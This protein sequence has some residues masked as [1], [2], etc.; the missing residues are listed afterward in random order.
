MK[1]AVQKSSLNQS[2]I[3]FE[4][5]WGIVAILFF[6]LFSASIGQ[7]DYPQWYSVGTTLLEVVAFLV[8]ALLCIRNAFSPT[9]V[10]S[11]RVW[12]GLGLGMAFYF[13]GN[14]CFAYWEIVLN[15]E[16]DVSLGD[17]FYIPSYIF[18]ILAMATAAFE[19]RLNLEGW[20]YGVIGGVG[21]VGVLIAIILATGGSEEEAALR[22]NP[23]AMPP[24]IAADA[25]LVA[26]NGDRRLAQ[27][28]AQAKPKASPA[29]KKPAAPPAIKAKPND[30]AWVLGVENTLK[31]LAG[32]VK[33]FYLIADTVLLIFATT[34]FLAFWGGRFAQSWRMIAAGTFCLYFADAWFN[35]A[36]TRL[37]NYQSGGLLEVGWVLSGVLFG[38]G[39]ALEYQVS[40]SR[41]SGSRRRA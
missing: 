9:I 5:I 30:P 14:L 29:I 34:L 25:P 31:P 38:L 39:A 7:E 16:P 40:Q 20:Q 19:R 32:L 13:V 23:L 36:T 21:V 37:T 15:R 1:T 17:L 3:T 11:R 10:S 18:L 28:L 4:V 41:R 8:A 27:Q 22:L 6:L 26:V 35:F 12:F 24:A 33:F 2:I